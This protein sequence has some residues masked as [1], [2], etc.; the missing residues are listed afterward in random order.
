MRRSR[1]TVTISVVAGVTVLAAGFSLAGIEGSKHDFS[2]AS[3]SDG[4]EC[5]ACHTPH[6]DEPPKAA[7]LWNPDADL[8]RTFGTTV[9]SRPADPGIGT[10]LCMRCHDGTIARDTFSGG[11]GRRWANVNNPAF[12][13][14]GHGG[15]DHPVGVDYP[16]IDRGYRP[17]AAV[18]AKRTVQ[19]PD[20]KVE[21]VSCHDPHNSSGQKYMLVADNARSRLC[22]TCHRK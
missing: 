12:F 11:G 20:G 4:D 7:P 1:R 21:C 17:Q 9:G 16:S 2:S 22:L 8:N 6:R 18:L 19:L 13:R 10:L 15:T 14:T 5:G 3:W